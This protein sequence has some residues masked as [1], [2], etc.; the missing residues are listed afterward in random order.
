MFGT[1]KIYCNNANNFW[2]LEKFN[3]KHVSL[4]SPGFFLFSRCLYIFTFKFLSKIIYS[5]TKNLSQNTSGWLL[6]IFM[7]FT[8]YLPVTASDISVQRVVIYNLNLSLKFI[9]INL[10]FSLLW[11]LTLG[12][13][14]MS[15]EFLLRFVFWVSFSHALQ[16]HF[17]RKW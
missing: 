12:H 6:L 10:T 5:I 3:C 13:A 14:S 16:E 2:I 9:T 7:F 11:V 8:K 4:K 1:L 17:Q 15:P